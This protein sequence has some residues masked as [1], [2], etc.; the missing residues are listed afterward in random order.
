MLSDKTIV[1]R[2][3]ERVRAKI[4]A[5]QKKYDDGCAKIDTAIDEEINRLHLKRNSSK[6]AL[7]DEIVDS[8]IK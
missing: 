6:T 8:I 2:V 5:G 4:A 3:T 1:R 7:A